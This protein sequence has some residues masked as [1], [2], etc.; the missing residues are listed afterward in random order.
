MKIFDTAN[1]QFTIPD[2]VIARPPAPSVS[3][4]KSSDLVF[5]YNSAPFAFW[6]TRRSNPHAAPLFDTRIASLPKT[7]IA[8]SSSD[9]S[10]ALDAFPLVFEDQYLQVFSLLV[11]DYTQIVS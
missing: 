4:S 7:P 8:A 6:I 3:H 11:L 5:N 1:K 9:N 2:S 10:T